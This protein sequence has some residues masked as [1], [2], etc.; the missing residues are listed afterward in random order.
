MLWQ[1]ILFNRRITKEEL[2]QTIS[3]VFSIERDSITIVDSPDEIAEEPKGDILCVHIM[4][5]GEY[6]MHVDICL[7]DK[8]VPN[9]DF[10]VIRKMTS[11][12]KCRCM[13]SDEDVNP[14]TMHEVD[15][16]GNIYSVELDPEGMDREDYT[17][18]TRKKMARVE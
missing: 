1:D 14:Y 18:L 2:A 5:K 11:F 8:L 13:V 4:T 7:D 15:Q 6:P 3:S 17:V 9:D 12:L 16:Q 10:E